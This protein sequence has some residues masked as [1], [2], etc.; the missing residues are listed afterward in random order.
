V[1]HVQDPDRFAGGLQV[2]GDVDCY[3]LDDGFQHLPLARD[4]DLVLIDLT[5]PFGGG[6]C[7]PGGRLREPLSALERATLVVLTRAELVAR[8]ALGN[9]MR[10]VRARTAAPI[11]TVSFRASC[12]ADLE[13]VE[14]T[15]ACGIGNPRAFVATV[16]R[17][18]VRPAAQRLFRDHHA[19]TQADADELARAGRPV[20]VTE[21]DAVK[22]EKMWRADVPLHVVRVAVEVTEGERELVGVVDA[23]LGHRP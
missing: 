8:E 4:A 23:A 18:G 15:V 16:E 20:V 17:L 5:D 9:V 11:A 14:A 10:S 2:A 3:V 13:G 22:L 7:P 21:K 19:Y 12:D 1:P 6:W